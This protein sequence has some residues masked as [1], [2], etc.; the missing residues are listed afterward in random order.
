[1]SNNHNQESGYILITT[2]IVISAIALL[3]AV[4]ILFFADGF[5][6]NDR[7]VERSNEAKG[8]ANA[9][10]ETAAQNIIASST[11]IG[12]GSLSLGSG[13]CTYTVTEPTGTTALINAT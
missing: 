6:K 13:S 4:S 5:I 7:A 12:S 9:C 3:A 1:M 2:A 11:F 10:G 8:L